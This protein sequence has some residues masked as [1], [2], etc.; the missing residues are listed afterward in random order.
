MTTID[1]DGMSCTSCEDNVTDA[2]ADLPAVES[3]SADHEAGTATVEGDAD[4]GAVVAAIEEAGY[5]A[6]A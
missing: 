6:S 3:A 2:L 5:E 1:V 4:V